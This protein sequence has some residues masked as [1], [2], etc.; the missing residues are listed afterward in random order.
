M[1]RDARQQREVIT[2]PTFNTP[3]G[4]SHN[5][6]LSREGWRSLG[7]SHVFQENT[8]GK[9]GQP[10]LTGTKRGGGGGGGEPWEK[11]IEAMG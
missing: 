5:L 9:G 10:Y 6:L 1:N 2:L 7:R 8:G 11:K 3:E 4:T